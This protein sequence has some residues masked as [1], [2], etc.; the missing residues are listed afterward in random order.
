MAAD[1]E[2]LL[3]AYLHDPPDKALG[4]HGHVARAGRY[5]RAIL[6]RDISDS[7]KKHLSDILASVAE[8]LP[9]PKWETLTVN[10]LQ[11][12]IRINHPLSGMEGNL[13]NC[14]LDE[15]GV[16]KEINTVLQGMGDERQWRLL[17][18]WR[19]LPECLAKKHSWF[20][21]LP[22]DTRIPD[23]TIWHHLDTTTALQAADESNR[24]AAFL[25]F[26]LGPVQSFINTARS[27]RDL[28]S[29]SMILSWLT[30]QAMLPVI[31]NYGPM[32]FVY[33]HL[34][35]IP[36]LD[37][38]LSEP[39]RVGHRIPELDDDLRRAPC[40]PNR[41]LAV[42][43]WGP[44]G[45][46]AY[47]VAE[48]SKQA[49]QKKWREMAEAVRQAL[50][51]QLDPLDRNWDER[52]DEQIEHFWDIQTAVLPLPKITDELAANLLANSSHFKDAFPEAAKARTLADAI[53]KE[54][55]PGYDQ[56]HAGRWQA[57]VELSARL[58]QS[59]RAIRHVPPS[60]T[61]GEVPL[62]CSLMGSYEQMGPVGLDDSRRFWEGDRD[63]HQ[64]G[65]VDIV[66]IHG[67]RLRK[68][69]RFCAPALVKRFSAPAFLAEEL[70]VEPA[71]LRFPDT[72]TVTA[73]EWIAR[74]GIDP[75]KER[76]EHDI[77]NGQWLHWPT[78]CF[79]SDEE[80]CPDELWNLIQRAKKDKEIGR[81]PAYYAILMMDADKMGEWL[82]GKK[83]PKVRNVLHPELLKYFEGLGDAAK[84]GLDARRP[85][86]PALH[87]ALSEAL[88]N[89]ALHFVP[90]IVKDH[91]GTLIYAG[92]DD[93]LALLPTSQVLACAF[94]LR[95][96]FQKN[97]EFDGKGCERL[98][99]GNSATVSAGIAVVH[100]KED[101]RFALD[102]A[103]KAEKVAK[104]AG[105]D[106]LSLTVCRRSGEHSSA[107]CPWDFVGTMMQWVEAFRK[108]ASD[109]WAYHLAGEL[110][111]LSLLDNEAMRAEIRRQVNRSETPTREALGETKER[112]AGEVIAARFEA[113]WKEV[114]KR[115]KE[116]EKQNFDC[117]RALSQFVTL[118]QSASF[119]ARGREQ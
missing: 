110:P 10:P 33:P 25:S 93:V 79:D 98:L 73:A 113:Y 89:F 94:K 32:A 104:N 23:H 11:A 16:V 96:T 99:P 24:G 95:Q 83:S 12:T 49:V 97:W 111:T 18:L 46:L 91:H 70:D 74:A 20:A 35:G 80:P 55:R 81:P 112:K 75:N 51:R 102:Q 14:H 31:E 71:D 105:R 78:Q 92:G 65:A 77:W 69:E 116:D 40:L 26:S 34:R 115:G 68:G 28:W 101:L 87:A 22:A 84:A 19:L 5:A 13:K 44:D 17:A 9:A 15:D 58:M 66:K 119:L 30:F 62:K 57:K 90:G 29:G 114:E 117:A 1:W 27:V 38:W 7:E 72:S 63:K 56:N 106:A 50:K 85:L 43:P 107:F 6:G 88:T 60:T 39:S 3:L 48:K 53:T 67:V 82:A 52:W 54:Q 41:F 64:K 109:R 37:R 59:Q 36:F 8:R 118:C 86:G 4:I 45:S 2:S 108:K 47:E 76:R 21:H 100:Y 61:D 42:V 103:R